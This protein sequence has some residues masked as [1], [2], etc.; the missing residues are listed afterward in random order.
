MT[1]VKIASLNLKPGDKLKYV[2]DF[3]DWIEHVLEVEA[4]FRPQYQRLPIL[5]LPLKTN[6][7]TNIA[8]PARK[9]G[10]KPSLSICV[11][12]SS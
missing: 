2:Y 7:V 4:Q 5:S 1:A 11:H 9:K 12:C 6:P 10:V 3:G 8:Q